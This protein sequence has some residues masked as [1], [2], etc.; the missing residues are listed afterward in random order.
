MTGN[1][2]GDLFKVTSFGES[3]GKCIG[4]VIDGC[5]AG[6]KLSEE[7]IQNE[8]D[9]RKPV[10]ENFS[11][12]RREEDKVE[13][14]SGIF[15]GYTTGA[16]ICMI[17]WNKDFDSTTYESIKFTPRPGHADY[18]AYIKYGGFN[19]YR[20]GGRFSGRITA[21]FVMAGAV[22]KR[23]LRLFNIEVLAYTLEIGGIRMKQMDLDEVIEY[24]EKSPVRCPDLE[25]SEKML[26][27]IENVKCEGDSLGGVVEC[28]ALNVPVGLGTPVFDTLEGDIS[29]A[30]YAI[31][32]VKGVEFGAGFNVAKLKGSENNDQYTIKDGKIITL[33]NNSGGILGGISNGMPIVCRVAI[34]P[35]SSISKKQFSIDLIK[36]E[37]TTLI[38]KGKHDVCI[39]PRAVPV[40][41]SMVAI[42]LVDHAIKTGIVP[43]VVKDVME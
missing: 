35:P 23:I 8:L 31:P 22:A 1:S 9:K 33:T 42:I 36:M 25:A 15:N 30:L 13:I 18:T 41:E 40:I 29:K 10:H 17:I 3:H 38:V 24:V 14:L 27:M 5:P 34:K 12:S 19:D 6:L 39:V 16:P 43:K 20:G 21:S 32:A 26:K 11:T 7:I 28:L 37:K 2:I 4:V